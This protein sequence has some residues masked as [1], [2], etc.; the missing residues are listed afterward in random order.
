MGENPLATAPSALYGLVLLMAAIG[1]WILQQIITAEQGANS[2]LKKAVGRDWKGKL[3]PLAY[4]IG[5]AAA[6]WSPRVAQVIY[7]V[8][9]ALWLVPD[10]RIEAVLSGQAPRRRP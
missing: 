3:S 5:I 2:L 6:Q 8:V 10:L 9:A 4:L 1:Y 7:L